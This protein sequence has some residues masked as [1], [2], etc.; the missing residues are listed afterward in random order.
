[1]TAP[2]RESSKATMENGNPIKN[3]NGLQSESP[4]MI[5]RSWCSKFLFRKSN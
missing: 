1:M 2:T 5:D 4:I 3:P